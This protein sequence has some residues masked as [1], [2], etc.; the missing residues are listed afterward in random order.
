MGVRQMFNRQEV[1]QSRRTILSVEQLEKRD[2]LSVAVIPVRIS[3]ASIDAGRGSFAGAL[4]SNT[5]AAKILLSSRH[6]TI[7]VH[8]GPKTIDLTSK[9]TSEVLVDLNHDGFRDALATFHRAS[10][11][12]LHAGKATITV[13]HDG[14]SESTNI[15]IF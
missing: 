9:A 1:A 8:Q 6:S 11:R 7:A 14:I 13:S 4:I 2:L 12:G 10:L 3:L 15:T 5:L